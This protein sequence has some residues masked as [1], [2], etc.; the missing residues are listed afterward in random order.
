MI[1][2]L[3]YACQIVEGGKSSLYDVLGVGKTANEKEIKKAYRKLA[4]KHHPD[5]TANLS[6][7]ARKGAEEKFKEVN[8]AYETLSDPEKRKLYDLYGEAGIETGGTPGA[9]AGYGANPFASGDGTNPFQ[10]FFGSSSTSSSSSRGGPGFRTETFSF[11]PDADGNI[12]FSQIL[13]QMMGGTST[14][15]GVF[16]GRAPPDGTGASSTGSKFHRSR[17]P[18]PSYSKKLTCSLEELATGATKKLRVAFQG[19]EK[20]YTIKLKPGWK[21]GTKIK[22]Q[23]SVGGQ[24][25]MTFIVQQAPHRFLRRSGDDLHYTCWIS[26][27]QTK[28]GIKINITL[29]TGEVWTKKIPRN[30]TLE[31]SNGE[32]MKIPSKGMPIKGGPERGDLVVEFRI[33]QSSQNREHP[34]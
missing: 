8:K 11:G 2:L 23:G 14:S 1:V 33:R 19:T 20:M 29:P 10:G 32:T 3:G 18:P 4:L 6:E 21:E 31:V 16:F 12:D 34:R 22:F 27:G 9:G 13:Q 17:T 25:T 5:K 15:S 28:G 7:K 24:P 30:N 26:E